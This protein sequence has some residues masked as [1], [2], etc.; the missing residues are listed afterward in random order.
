VWGA[1]Y[2]YIY[3][4]L[5]KY[6]RVNVKVI[7]YKCKQPPRQKLKEFLFPITPVKDYVTE[8]YTHRNASEISADSKVLCAIQ[9]R[10]TKL[11]P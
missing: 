7:H 10:D 6:K 9:K 4:R 1:L 5:A 3:E 8:K 11:G 2:I